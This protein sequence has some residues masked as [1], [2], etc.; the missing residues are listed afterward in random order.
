V[1]TAIFRARKDKNTLKSQIAV[2][3]QT[4]RI[5]DTAARVPGP[6]PDLRFDL[7][8]TVA[9]FWNVGLPTRGRLAIWA[10]TSSIHMLLSRVANPIRLKTIPTMPLMLLFG[11]SLNTPLV[12]SLLRKRAILFL[13][14]LQ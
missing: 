5:V 13:S 9:G 1:T 2:D 6:T 12:N 14:I 7:A 11:L 3:G 8:Q 4:G 10:W